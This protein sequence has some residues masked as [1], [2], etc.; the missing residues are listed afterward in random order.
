MVWCV[1]CKEGRVVFLK[2]WR[3]FL[4]GGMKKRFLSKK[5]KHP[6]Y[7]GQMD[8]RADGPPGR[9]IFHWKLFPSCAIVRLKYRTKNNNIN[10]CVFNILYE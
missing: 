6:P 1:K 7:S 8:L 10:L 4:G 3:E 5:A 2:K 9:F